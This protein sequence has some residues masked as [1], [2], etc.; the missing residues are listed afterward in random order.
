VERAVGAQGHA[1]AGDRQAQCGGRRGDGRP[2][3]Q[4]A[5][6][7]ARAGDAADER[8]DAGGAC[9]P[10]EGRHREMVA[11][12]Q[13]RGH[14]ASVSVRAAMRY[15]YVPMPDRKPLKW[16][17]GQRLVVMITLNLEYWE[18]TQD[19][20]GP[21]VPGGPSINDRL[22]PARM[23]DF[24]NHSWREYGQRIGVWRLYDEFDAAGVPASCAVSGILCERHPR[25]VTAASERGWEMIGH[26]YIQA[27]ALIDYR[28][29]PARERAVIVRTLDAIEKATGRRPK[30]WL[31]SGLRC[32]V[33]TSDI[34][35]ELGLTYHCDYMN[36]EQPYLIKTA[37]GPLVSIP[38]T[39]EA[40]DI[41]MFLR[42]NLTAPE[43]FELWKDEFDE[44]YRSAEKS[45]RIMSI[46]LH[47]HIIGRAFRAR[48]IRE[49]L[50]YA[51]KF[52][53]VWWTTRE[54]IADWYLQNHGSH[55]G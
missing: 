12:P 24:N 15:D 13:G 29:D 46:G 53:G 52:D 54:E 3:V 11:A 48:A 34:L 38:Y 47:P 28:D 44:L 39:Q 10:A 41:G 22:L 16:P 37:H 51:K 18:L 14:Q 25:I 50:D 19:R 2:G 55:I 33:N 20:D 17:N 49:F 35:K 42:R 30:G 21:Y 8:A 26:N 6:D 45:G 1:A 27:D 32:T 7:P 5:H 40:N 43:A 23:P 31:S 36:D 4:A 9:R